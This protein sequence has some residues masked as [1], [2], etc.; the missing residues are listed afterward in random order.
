MK[1]KGLVIILVSV[2]VMSACQTQIDVEAEKAAIIEVINGE[3]DAY[4]NY[5]Y[6]K[7]ISYFVKDSLSFRQCAGA[8][9]VDFQ[10]GWGQ[11][12]AF[13]KSDLQGGDP[14]AFTDTRIN[15]TKDNYQIKVYD[16]SAYVVCT[17]RWT[18]TTS[19]NVLE[20]DSR[21]VRFMEKIDG[22]W[23]I[24][25]LSFIGTSGY[26]QEEELEELGVEFNSVR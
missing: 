9:N 19:D 2:L 25:F 18:Y 16:N 3:T 6:D 24:A 5:D 20:I 1:I 11:I 23:K 4:L 8:D 17:E 12:E 7:V 26:E 13:F 14:E 15:V 21:Q 22:E 10:D